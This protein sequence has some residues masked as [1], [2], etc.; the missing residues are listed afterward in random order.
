VQTLTERGVSIELHLG[1]GWG[2]LGCYHWQ[3]ES[4]LFAG[5]PAGGLGGEAYADVLPR[6]VLTGLGGS[7]LA[8]SL[9]GTEPAAHHPIF[10]WYSDVEAIERGRGRLVFCQYRIFTEPGRDPLADR[11]RFNLLQ[12]ASAGDRG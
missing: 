2:W 3:P 1:L 4:A 6:Y 9:K 11:M 5:L 8:G 12:L 7:V 10:H